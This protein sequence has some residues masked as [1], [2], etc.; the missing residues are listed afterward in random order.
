MEAKPTDTVTVEYTGTFDDGTV[1]D[2]SATHGAPLVFEIGTRQVIRGFEDGVLGMKKGEE[3]TITIEPEKAY[4]ISHPQLIR[5]VPVDEF[6]ADVKLVP[7]KTLLASLNDGKQVPV[8][9]K[10]MTEKEITFDFN[11]PLAGKTLHFKLKLLEIK[12]ASS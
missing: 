4:G 7:G 2:S 1:F 12:P 9:V 3:K 5:V 8:T 10:S 6:P 11:H